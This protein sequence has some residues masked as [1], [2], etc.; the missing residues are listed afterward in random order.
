[1]EARSWV[2]RKVSWSKG[3]SPLQ[4]LEEFHGPREAWWAASPWGKPRESDMWAHT[5]IFYGE[6]LKPI[7]Q[8]LFV[9]GCSHLEPCFLSVF[10]TINGLRIGK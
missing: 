9:L 8:L 4:Y 3:N 7:N 2:H 6:C 10:K 5:C 1:M